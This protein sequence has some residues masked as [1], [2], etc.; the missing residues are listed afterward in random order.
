MMTKRS[1]FRRFGAIIA[2]VAIAPE[3]AFGVRLAVQP[4]VQT[5]DLFELIDSVYALARARKGM[6]SMETIDIYTDN[7]GVKALERW[8]SQ[9]VA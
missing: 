8:Q 9:L 5:L 3:I 2:A 4:K 7:E 6:S 1:F